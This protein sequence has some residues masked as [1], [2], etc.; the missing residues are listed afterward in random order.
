MLARPKPFEG[1]KLHS[2]V[3]DPSRFKAT[4]EIGCERVWSHDAARP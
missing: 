1:Y 4:H 3:C 2:G